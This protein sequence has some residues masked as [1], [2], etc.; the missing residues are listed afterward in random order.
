MFA[1][2][3][4][5][6]TDLSRAEV[7]YLAGG[8]FWCLEAVFRRV[9]G[10]IAVTSGF[11][12]GSTVNPTYLDVCNGK[13][14]HSEVIKMEFDPTKISYQQL[15]D[16]FWEAHDPTRFNAMFDVGAQYRSTIFYTDQRQKQIAT[17][18]KAG[19]Q[20]HF[21]NPIVTAILPFE[22]FYSADARHQGYYERNIDAPYCQVVVTP[23]LEALENRGI[24]S[25]KGGN[26][27]FNRSQAA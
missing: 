17:I 5:A 2:S 1:S 24:I 14:G 25:K 27:F 7:A 4:N 19:A 3:I 13:T 16:V 20:N 6:S 23:R 15:L 18:S 12:G 21:A 9:P 26:E 10:V 11:A 8:A 22:K